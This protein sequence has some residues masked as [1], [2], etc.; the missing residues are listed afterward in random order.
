MIDSHE[1]ESTSAVAK[2]KLDPLKYKW[3]VYDGRPAQFKVSAEFDFELKKG[4]IFGLKKVKETYFLLDGSYMYVQFKLK[5]ADAKRILNNSK[6]Y[7][8][9]VGRVSVQ[10]GTEA[11]KDRKRLIVDDLVEV[12]CDSSMLQEM[13]Y[14]KKNKILYVKFPNGA[15]WKYMD[16]TAEEVAVLEKAKSQGRYFND[17]IKAVKDAERFEHDSGNHHAEPSTKTTNK[18]TAKQKIHITYVSSPKVPDGFTEEYTFKDKPG[19]GFVRDGIRITWD[20]GANYYVNPKTGEC[21]IPSEDTVVRKLDNHPDIV[22]KKKLDIKT[23]EDNVGIEF[24]GPGDINKD[25]VNA[26]L[27]DRKPRSAPF[28][29]DPFKNY[30]LFENVTSKEF[31]KLADSLGF[32]IPLRSRAVLSGNSVTSLLHP[33]SGEVLSYHMNTVAYILGTPFNRKAASVAIRKTG[34][35]LCWTGKRK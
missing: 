14:D 9:K 32:T 12:R 30:T 21:Y 8:G 29:I 27:G 6:S 20:K 33:T 15:E 1:I 22:T 19:V 13:W 28:V 11:G 2:V 17:N 23:Q 25:K 5:E 7:S 34:R 26:S 31:K 16:V 24:N 3:Y 4:E 35:G 10:P 18:D